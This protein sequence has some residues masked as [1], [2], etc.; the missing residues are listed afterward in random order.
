MTKREIARRELKV[1]A[2]DKTITVILYEPRKAKQGWSCDYSIELPT[3]SIAK[4]VYGADSL[5]ALMLALDM[6]QA[7]VRHAEENEEIAID[8]EGSRF[9]ISPK[10]R[11]RP[12]R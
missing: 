4:T 3:R 8:W 6:L 5:H 1:R 11:S 7:E 10:L 2:N 9:T 12:R